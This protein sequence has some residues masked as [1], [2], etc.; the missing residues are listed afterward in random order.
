[1]PAQAAEPPALL[2]E[3][4]PADRMESLLMR[5]EQCF[6]IPQRAPDGLSPRPDLLDEL[7]GTI[8]SQNTTDAN[9]SRAFRAL[10]AAFP[11]WEAV[12]A[13][14]PA[15]LVQCDSPRRLGPP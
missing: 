13:A 1:V 3:L 8:L 15:D 10:K 14:D 12:L 2:A 6:G 9:S 7:V 4:P 11:S 5:L